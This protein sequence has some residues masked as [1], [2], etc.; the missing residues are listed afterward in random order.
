MNDVLYY[1]STLELLLEENKIM[2]TKYKFADKTEQLKRANQFFALGYCVFYAL[3]AAI[4]WIYC[5]LGIRSMGLTVAMTII[6]LVCTAIT[7]VLG[8]V[9]L[10]SSKYKYVLLPIS[11]IIGFF[12][13]FAF[14]EGFIQLLIIFPFIAC[15]LYYDRKFAAKA[16]LVYVVL[17]ILITVFK[18][19]GHT[20]LEGGSVVDQVFVAVVYM[21]LLLLVNLITNVTTQFN[22]DALGQAN[23]ERD[24]MQVMMNDV[25]D[26]ASEVRKGTENAMEIV[27]SLNASTEIV[28]GAMRDI[29]SSTL[30]TAE[31]I[32]TQTTMTSNIQDAI[33]NTL[34]SSE[35]MV[36]VAEESGKLNNQSLDVMNQLKEQS[37][38]IS[39]TNSEV[40]TA[41]KA[42]KERTD[43]V[44]SIADTIF[45]ISSQTNLL[46]LNASIE[47]A[48]AGEAGR[49][50]A[51]VADEI[52]QLAEKTRL[53]T[54]SIANIS[55]ELSHTAEVAADAV[56]QSVDATMAQDGMITEASEC[57][58][59]MNQNMNSLI[60]E[61]QT[62]S[63]ML[64]NLSAANNQIVD[65]ITNL[66]ATTE[67][68]T[69][70]SAQATDLSVENLENA[71]NARVQLNSVLD[72][73]HQLDKY[74]Q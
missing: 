54:E 45:S 22:N 67:E 12:I 25:M 8:K 10:E 61:I 42:L 49:G 63:E 66:S 28:N 40:A 57:F 58:N 72:V 21:F 14:S 34:E 2:D 55:E 27:N 20:N 69:A 68:V 65:N 11:F 62:L 46:A 53:E 36:S 31:N 74:L 71:E 3:I 1:S 60:E 30:S 38:V 32:Q 17:E 33:E 13:G 39:D 26:V 35:K 47:S 9:L 19:S 7:V 15:I 44:K 18:I 16:T 23:E 73:S 29:S 5:M 64:N 41:M 56:Q 4:M 50:F 37:Q 48:R 59:E 43:A 70:S 24:K 6:L 52:R 51:V